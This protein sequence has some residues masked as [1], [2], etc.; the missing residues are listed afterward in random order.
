MCRIKKKALQL[1]N[2]V[3]QSTLWQDL[4]VN[5]LFQARKQARSPPESTSIVLTPREN[6]V[7]LVI[8]RATE[9]FIRVPFQNL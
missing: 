2:G 4:R 8:E 6:N 1:K 9:Y 5:F 7:P 3:S